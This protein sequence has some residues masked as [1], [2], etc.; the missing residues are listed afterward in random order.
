VTPAARIE[1][2]AERVE[3]LLAAQAGAST[4]F[5]AIESDG[6]LAPGVL[7]S[8]ASAAIKAMAA[9]QL[10]VTRHWHK[11][12]V[13]SGPNTLQPYRENPP[14]RAVAADDIV[15]LDLGP[16]F[17]EWEADFGRTYVLGDDPVKQQLRAD[18][19]ILFAAGCE[20]FDSHPDVTGE[21]LYAHVVG[22]AESRGWTWGG[23]IAG[24][25]VGQFPHDEP[26]GEHLHALVAPGN[27]RPMRCV[28]AEGRLC[29]WI[30][31]IHIVDLQ[32]QFGGFYEELLDIRP[33]A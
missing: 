32:R 9:A 15:F 20:Y 6:V 17:E 11:R 7:E 2:E 4:L 8:T 12:V 16:I 18:L 14:D 25:V 3:R 10:G 30:L 26:I 24:H 33:P 1:D 28:D 31:E 13:R 22:L 5:D 19:P 29:H 21:E 23:S 27:D